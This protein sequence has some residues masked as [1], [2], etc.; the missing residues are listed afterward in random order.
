MLKRDR[1]AGTNIHRFGKQE[2]TDW[3]TDLSVLASGDKAAWLDALLSLALHFD[4]Q[5]PDRM[6][7]YLSRYP[8]FE[9]YVAESRSFL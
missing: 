8:T 6:P 3:L 4:Q 9:A 2:A 7:N 1:A 5:L